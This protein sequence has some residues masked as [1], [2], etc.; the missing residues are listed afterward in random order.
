M[1]DTKLKQLVTLAVTLDRQIADRQADLK[2]LKAQIVAEAKSRPE[3]AVETDGGGVSTTLEGEDGSVA[4]VTVAGRTL[5]SSIDPEADGFDRVKEAAGPAGFSR[6]FKPAVV[7]QL[8]DNFRDEAETLLGKG[9]SKLVKLC[10]SAG[11]TTVSFET[12]A[13]KEPAVAA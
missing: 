5:R 1:N 4:R 2:L 7:Y 13:A 8:V 12:K 3:L 11:K 9:A 10:T 6:L